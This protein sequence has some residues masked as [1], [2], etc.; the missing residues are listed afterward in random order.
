MGSAPARVWKHLASF[1]LSSSTSFSIQLKATAML[2]VA[3][4]LRVLIPNANWWMDKFILLR[5]NTLEV[6]QVKQAPLK[7][8][9]Y[10][11]QMVT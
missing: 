1:G 9:M 4:Q 7:V 6:V 5:L 11:V 3:T 2:A 8:P 10:T